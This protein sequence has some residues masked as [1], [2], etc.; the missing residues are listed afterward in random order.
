MPS[1]K[2]SGAGREKLAVVL[3]GNAARAAAHLGALQSVVDAGLEPGV[4]VG[5]SGGAIAGALYAATGSAEAAR[6]QLYRFVEQHS[7]QDL[8]DIDF[9]A[10][11]A[12]RTRPYEV[13]G[14]LKG[15]KLL[16][17]LLATA[18][19]H[20]GF[21]HLDVPLFIVGADLN[22]GRE[23]VFCAQTQA[24]L[25]EQAAYRV[26]ARAPEDLERVNVAAACRASCAVPGLVQ[27]LSLDYMCVVDGTLRLRRALAVAAAQKGVKRILWLHAGLDENDNYSLVTDYAGQSFAA[28]L[29]QAL[30]LAAADQF[31]PHTADPALDGIAVRYV[32]LATSGIG[33]V[34]LTKTQQLVE[35]GRRSVGAI[36]AKGDVFAMPAAELKAALEADVHPVDGA[37]WGVTV[38]AG[39]DLVAV[40]DLMPPAQQEFGYEFDDYLQ[41]QGA[42]KLAP[43][44]PQ[45]TSLWGRRLAEREVG[46]LR[47]TGR[48]L[49]Q[50]CG[51]LCRSA[52]QGLRIACAAIRLDQAWASLAEAVGR[53]ALSVRQTLG[54]APK[55]RAAEATPPADESA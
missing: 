37:R 27:P 17:T 36:L 11:A 13:S 6:D 31:D 18:L 40:T 50:S 39:R 5:V 26:F 52:R 7:W 30:T 49:M 33:T 34:E 44:E 14:F 15:A 54:P 24:E 51:L 8:A 42:A 20:R 55:K 12:L 38:G 35:S 45:A 28:G 53:G 21:Q 2:S 3:S 9:A 19:G 32:N 47:L 29:S 25:G 1:R 43:R 16:E 10:L 23:V 4:V 41:Q 22:S 48:S 46:L